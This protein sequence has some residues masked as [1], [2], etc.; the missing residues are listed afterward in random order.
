MKKT[1]IKGHVKCA[2]LCHPVKNVLIQ[3]KDDK[4]TVTH[5]TLS[6]KNGRYKIQYD[7]SIKSM[8]FKKDGYVTKKLAFNGSAPSIIRLLE[9][10]II[11]YQEKHW[12]TPGETIDAY[13]HATTSFNAKLIRYGI[14][15]ETI[16]NLGDHDAMLQ[17]VPDT[18]FVKDGLYW[19]KTFSYQLPKNI[20][21]GMYGL[22]LSSKCD[23]DDVYNITFIVSPL[24][25][26]RSKNAKLLVI[27][28]TNNWQTYNI[29]GGR[30]R[31]RNFET[32]KKPF[33]FRSK[34]SA[35]FLRY[36][37]EL[38]KQL[39]KNAFCKKAT[40]TIKDH[41]DLWKFCPLSI[42]RPHPNCS[43]NQENV[44]NYFTSHLASGE[45]RVL[46]WLEREEIEYDVI[47]GFEL[48]CMPQILHSYSAVMLNTHSEYWSG[49]MY[50]TLKNFFTK[51][52]SIFN[53]SGNSI[54][55]EVIFENGYDIKCTSLHFS[56]SVE[57]ESKFL[58]VK[59]NMKGYGTCAPYVVT[60]HKHWV[61]RGT[62]LKQGSRFAN[63]SLNNSSKTKITGKYDPSKPGLAVLKGNGGSGWET[64][65]LT[66]SAPDDTILLAKGAN[67]RKGG[68]DMIIRERNGHGILFSASSITFGGSLLIDDISSKIM[69]N[70]LEKAT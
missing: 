30:S 69:K 10:K 15:K 16:L 38:L 37:P 45:W 66:P 70:I 47:S 2:A 40:V 11:G 3:A 13:V 61:F 25:K 63:S 49:E 59:F 58:G 24:M 43:I 51:G 1:L 29:W 12:F 39:I 41:P 5:Q 26:N 50:S 55:R 67:K 65:K 18:F 33:N 14:K 46:A 52:G 27:A 22:Q 7:N 44:Y 42:R 19:K 9:S 48:H 60:H 32:E 68:A 31:Y 54:Y 17:E 56:K 35:I 21:S 34:I 4:N 23:N 64:D 8:V 6:N 57:D 62:N 53:L 36:M 28:S 20:S